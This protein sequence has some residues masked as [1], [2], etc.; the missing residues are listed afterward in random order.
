MISRD[1]T[2]PVPLKLL[3]DD[4]Y[5]KICLINVTSNQHLHQHQ[6]CQMP[7]FQHLAHK[8]P[9]TILYEMCQIPIF[10]RVLQHV[11]NKFYS[12][13]LIK[14]SEEIEVLGLEKLNDFLLVIYFI[15]MCYNVKIQ[16][17]CTVYA[18]LKQQKQVFVCYISIWHNIADAS[19]LI[20][21]RDYSIFKNIFTIF[22]NQD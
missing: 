7:I 18:I 19:T 12:F 2:L 14:D 1:Y 21:F 15:L 13:F 10:R 6:V 9:K 3:N 5:H 16:H 4:T 8:I 17:F 11:V 22:L 20:I